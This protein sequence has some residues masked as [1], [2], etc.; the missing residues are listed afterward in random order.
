MMQRRDSVRTHG[1]CCCCAAGVYHDRVRLLVC[2]LTEHLRRAGGGCGS[3][4]G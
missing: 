4:K 2:V 3:T 1:C